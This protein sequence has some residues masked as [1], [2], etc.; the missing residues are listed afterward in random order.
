MRRST[1]WSGLIGL[2]VALAAGG[3]VALAQEPDE[4][5]IGRGPQFLLASA[6][7]SERPVA[8]DVASVPVL[9]RRLSLDLE[10]AGRA[11]ALD[12]ISKASGLRLVYANGVSLRE[13]RVRLKADQITV[14]A[15]LTEV[16]LDAGVD[17]LLARSGDAVLVRRTA[18]SAPAVGSIVGRV[19]DA[20]TQSALAGAT[21]VVEGTR[22]SATTGNDGRY[23]IAEVAP[24]TYTVRA[25]Y[26]GYTPGAASVT[27]NADQEAA[28]DFGLEKSAQRLNE[29]VTTGTVVPT[30]VKGCRRQSAL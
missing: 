23:R 20:K 16:L 1:L 11:E 4:V 27:V 12:A 28:A 3:S 25:R 9:R 10:D 26:I 19:T 6:R 14:A 30:E 29:V 7:P 21:V 5:A 2:A 17:V 18:V 15:A 22:H 24:A 8:V 13:G